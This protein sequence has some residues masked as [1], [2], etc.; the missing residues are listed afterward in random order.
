M[1]KAGE[2]KDMVL[3]RVEISDLER[4]R[5]CGFGKWIDSRSSLKREHDKAVV[6]EEKE[7]TVC[8]NFRLWR[9]TKVLKE[10][11]KGKKM[12]CGTSENL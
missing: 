7:Q 8:V 1:L 2:P 12:E 3:Y 10:G 9:T 4:Q 6:S 5:T 11:R